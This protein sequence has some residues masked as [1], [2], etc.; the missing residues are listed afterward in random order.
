MNR[1]AAGST[2]LRPECESPRCAHSISISLRSSLLRLASS[3]CSENLRA[4]LNDAEKILGAFAPACKSALRMSHKLHGWNSPIRPLPT[5]KG[6]NSGNLGTGRADSVI[7]SLPSRI[8][9]SALDLWN[10]LHQMHLRTPGARQIAQDGSWST[11]RLPAQTTEDCPGKSLWIA[12][13]I[14]RYWSR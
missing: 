10:R 6:V 13:R 5:S 1:L 11:A 4:I 12:G 8:R 7:R 3:T 2:L 9:L 14:V